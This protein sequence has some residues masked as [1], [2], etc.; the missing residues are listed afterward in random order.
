MK[1]KISNFI[2][3]IIIFFFIAVPLTS[4]AQEKVTWDYPVKPGSEEW[5]ALKNQK[6]KLDICQIPES[7][8][9]NISTISLLN[10]CFSYPLVYDVLAFN[11]IQTG[12]NEFKKNFNGINEFLQ[13][14]DAANLL[15][16]KYSK[17]QPRGYDKNWNDI[18]KGYYSLE[19]SI[20]ELFLSQD[21]IINK[22]TLTEKQDLI[23]ELLKKL[24]EKEDKE[25]Y[26]IISQMSIVFTLSRI[27]RN[28]GFRWEQLN[29]EIESDIL[30]F[31]EYG[32]F[33]DVK[34]L[35]YIVSSSKEFSKQ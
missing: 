8:L 5:K 11:S 24:E 7:I 28:L 19:I 2:K 23:K 30:K 13:R 25:L 26:G 1:S 34:I 6:E 18:Q 31:T 3:G 20:I 14:K 32:S 9:E 22:M 10:L 17:I 27:L 29:E 33:Q 21:E 15:V 12:M 16:E 4:F 35:P